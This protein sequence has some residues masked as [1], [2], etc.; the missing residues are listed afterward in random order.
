[1]EKCRLFIN[2]STLILII[3]LILLSIYGAFLGAADA[4]KF[5]NSRL[6][7]AYW[8]ILLFVLSAGLIFQKPV[9]S[10]VLLI[11]LGCILVLAGSMYGSELGHQIQRK[12]F[13]IDSN[14]G[15]SVVYAG[16]L[17]LIAGVFWHFWL[18]HLFGKA[19]K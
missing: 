19:G 3:L 12:F 16:Y 7:T 2:W 11:Y 15:L 10:G 18:R 1:M 13:G 5:F 4:Q 6:I 14:S 17:T 8:L 9:T